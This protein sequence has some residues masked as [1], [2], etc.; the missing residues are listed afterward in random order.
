M[1]RMEREKGIAKPGVVKVPSVKETK[2][3]NKLRGVISQ[4]EQALN[5]LKALYGYLRKS[6]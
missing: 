3:E 5:E 2:I 6:R 1:K 4:M